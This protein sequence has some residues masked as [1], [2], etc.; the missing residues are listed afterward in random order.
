MLQNKAKRRLHMH[1]SFKMHTQTPRWDGF[2]IISLLAM[3]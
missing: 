3:I 2:Y 1:V